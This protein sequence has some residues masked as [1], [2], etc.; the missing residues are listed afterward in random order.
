MTK[1]LVKHFH[2]WGYQAFKYLIYALLAYNVVLFF[3]EESLASEVTFASGFTFGSLI[4][5]F[6]STIDT[7]AWVVLLL[8]FELETYVL[9]DNK[10]K[11][12]TKWSLHG[13][14]IFCYLFIVYAFYGYCTKLGLLS[15]FSTTD[16]TELCSLDGNWQYMTTL[17]EYV[18]ITQQNCQSFANTGGFFSYPDIAVVTNDE[19]LF[20]T[21]GLAWVDVIN[22]GA[23][24]FVVLMLE[25]D[26]RIQLGHV[27][28]A[29]WEKYSHLI[30]G[31]IYSILLI[32][33]IF[34]G[35]EGDFVDFWDAFL[36]LVAFFLIELNVF[37]WQAE[38]AQQQQEATSE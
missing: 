9:E 29:F 8:L 5:A 17:N 13:V 2:S 27:R 37:E 6:S 31:F 10:I 4:E 15:G 23:W 22:A 25:L 36:W 3:Q 20:A 7:A 35:F 38:N 21:Y 33:A 34:W 11:G 16:I 30:K 19:D 26:V 14:R 1:A 18:A 24:L 32:A 28:N 12:T